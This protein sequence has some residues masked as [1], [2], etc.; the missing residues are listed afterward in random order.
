MYSRNIK[1]KILAAL[2]DTPAIILCG[3][4]QTG[5]STLAQ[6]LTS[7]A[8]KAGYTSFDDL[9]PF[10][11]AK[12]DPAGFIDKAELPII[13]DEVQRVPEI[14]LPIKRAIDKNR[15]P[16]GFFLTGSANVLFLPKL[17]DSLAGRV[18]IHTLW[19]LSQ[20]EIH[21]VNTDI[22]SSLFEGSVPRKSPRQTRKELLHMLVRGGYPDVLSREG[23]RAEEWYASYLTTTLQRDVRDIADIEGLTKL[24]KLVAL[25]ASR[26]GTLLN[27]SDVSN[28]IDIPYATLHRYM[29]LL[30]MTYFIV[31]I[32]AWTSNIGL[33]L[34]KSPKVIINDTGLLCGI[35]G[36]GSE[37][38]EKDPNLLGGVL[39]SFVGMELIKLLEQSDTRAA[40]YH[41]RSHDRKEIDFVLEKPDGQLVAIEVKASGTLRADDFDVIKTFSAK[42]GMKLSAGVVLYTG[43]T[44]VPFGKN[45]IGAPLSVLWS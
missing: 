30:Q 42:V 10:S 39:E 12:E 32:P 4:R 40:L 28:A 17:A 44:V 21:D 22:I 19:P 23:E 11:V 24:P 3:A 1:R 7:R 43:E 5:K 37:R 41:F 33:R 8:W 26:S 6:S 2:K 29:A 15:K 45:L 13:I 20:Q 36:F 38:F 14:F 27:L 9:A 18:E 25:L 34:V 31:S 16:G 35:L